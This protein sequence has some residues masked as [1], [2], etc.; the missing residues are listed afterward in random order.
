MMKNGTAQALQK[1]R[2]GDIA[3][4]VNGFGFPEH[5]QGKTDLPFP[6]VKVSDMNAPGSEVVV[7]SAANTVDTAILT[8]IRGKT[9]PPGTIVFPK[10]GGA[11]LTNKKRILG[12]RA[13]F[14]NNVMGVVPRKANGDWLYYWLLNFDLKTLANTQALPSIRQSDVA[15]L[16]LEL[17]PLPEQRRIAALLREQL[18]TVAEA[19]AAFQAQLDAAQALP[20]AHIRAAFNTPAARAWPRRHI[21]DVARVQSGYAFKSD[22]FARTG[23]RLLRNVNV[24]QG[25]ISWDQSARIADERRPEFADYELAVGDIILSL[26]RPVVSGGLKLARI[27]EAD[28]PAL[29]LQRVGRFQILRDINPDFLFQFLST[30][31]FISAITKHDQS[32]GVPHVSPKQVEA[33]ELPVPRL[34]DQARLAREMATLSTESSRHRSVIEDCLTALDHMPAA[35]LREA[36]AGRL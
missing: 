7:S 1:S 13:S 28:L 2:L 22:W 25:C 23:V 14:D 3:D 29:L 20:A 18:A 34:P 36:F 16:L 35:L 11:L 30:Q 24:S 19:R 10:A 32:L 33:V 17:P 4:V 21:G 6:F 26:D 15:N 8:Q 31:T 5:L 27:S 12:V 9:Y